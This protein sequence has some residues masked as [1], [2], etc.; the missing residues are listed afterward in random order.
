LSIK[1]S[2]LAESLPDGGWTMA[3][4]P[5]GHYGQGAKCGTARNRITQNWL[6][7]RFDHLPGNLPSCPIIMLLLITPVLV[8]VWRLLFTIVEV[9]GRE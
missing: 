9:I 3:E 5:L 8:I 7:K 2:E 1:I 4:V 6:Q